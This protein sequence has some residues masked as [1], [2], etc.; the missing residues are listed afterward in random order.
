MSKTLDESLDG[1]M[2]EEHKALYKEQIDKANRGEISI[3][4]ALRNIKDAGVVFTVP[5]D[6]DKKTDTEPSTDNR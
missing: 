1:I 2:S 6:L 4:Q 3:R 5:E